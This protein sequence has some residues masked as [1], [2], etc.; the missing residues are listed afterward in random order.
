VTV[1][2]MTV[3]YDELVQRGREAREQ[4]DGVQWTQG[5]LA[6]QVEDLAPD[7]RPHDPQTGA[8]LPWDGETPLK[9]YAAEIDVAYS[10]LKNYRATARAWPPARRRADG[11][12]EVH[13][14]LN[15]LEDR[16]ALIH[17]G[18]TLVEARAI[19]TKRFAGTSRSAPGW[20]ELLGGVGDALKA[21]EKAMNKLEGAVEGKDISNPRM[22]T[23]ADEYAAWGEAVVARLRNLG[24]E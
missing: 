4:A 14:A 5:D 23:L 21:A 15:A 2:D 20:L 8:F 7:L 9:R 16:F 19:V 1:A 3:T 13:R 22:L 17:D 11:S 12:F 6:L 10:T 24:E 18:M